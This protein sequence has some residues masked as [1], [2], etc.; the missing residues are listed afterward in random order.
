[1]KLKYF[2]VALMLFC[3]GCGRGLDYS[4]G[5]RQGTIVKFSKK[6][7]F[8]KTWEGEMVLGGLRSSEGGAVAN[9]WEFSVI[10]EKLV[11]LVQQAADSGERIKLSYHQGL[12]TGVCISNSDYFVTSVE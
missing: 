3:V 1:M 7:V 10:D 12:F 6:G 8:C 4:D 5:S 9:V 11:P 2:V